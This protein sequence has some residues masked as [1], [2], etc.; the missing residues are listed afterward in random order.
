MECC[1]GRDE[2]LPGIL[3]SAHYLAMQRSGARM[4]RPDSRCSYTSQ[5]HM[6]ILARRTVDGQRCAE[7]KCCLSCERHPGHSPDMRLELSI[8]KQSP[9]G[10]S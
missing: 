10:E 1:V 5:L 4:P 3:M 9:I 8:A 7:E 6:S 2:A